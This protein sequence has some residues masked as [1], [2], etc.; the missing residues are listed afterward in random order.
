MKILLIAQYFPPEMGAL[1]SRASELAEVWASENQQVSILTGFPNY[2]AGVVPPEYKDKLRRLVYR[3]K[4]NGYQVVRTWLT[5]LSNDRSSARVLGY[6]S[7]FFS[8]MLTGLFLPRHDVIIASSPPLTVGLSGWL[9]SRIR[10]IPFILEIR[11]LWPESITASGVS[12]QGSLLIRILS[13]MANFLYQHSRNIVV[14]SPAFREDLHIKH[15]V[16]KNKVYLVPNGVKLEYFLK[17]AGGAEIVDELGLKGQTIAAY[18]GNY[19]WA[20]GLMTVIQAASITREMDCNVAYLF[21]GGG[22]DEDNLKRTV[23][24]QN[25][26]NVHFV[27]QQPKE[28]VPD[29]IQAA[30]ICLVPLRDEPVFET[31]IPSKMF[32]FMASSRPV[33]L[34]AKGQ[35]RKILEEARAGIAVAPQRPE[36]LASAIVELAKDKDR[37]QR[38]GEN[39]RNYVRKHFDR[40][41]LALQYLDVI[42]EIT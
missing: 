5:T 17:A 10:R 38:L 8:S 23:E 41:D 31:V 16:D 18:I 22:A 6:L 29:Y 32:E 14:V 33:V 25:L 1:A 21:V 24:E 34:S 35:V 40:R 9:I 26:T 4:V 7:F 11:D 27:H 36:E 13:W 19:G 30:D 39:G 3:E 37:R 20:Q 42:R 28:R 12:S 15:G 2:P